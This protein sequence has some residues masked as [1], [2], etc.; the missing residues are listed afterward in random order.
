MNDQVFLP[1]FFAGIYFLCV[2]RRC[3]HFKNLACEI[4]SI[5]FTVLEPIA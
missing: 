4:Q 5:V 2:H 3:Q 1:K